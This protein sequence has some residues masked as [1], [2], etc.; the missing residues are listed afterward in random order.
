M[1]TMAGAVR[2][3]LPGLLLRQPTS[4]AGGGRRRARPVRHSKRFVASAAAADHAEETRTLAGY[5]ATEGKN[6]FMLALGELPCCV[7]GVFRTSAR[8]EC[9]EFYV[10]GTVHTP[11]S[12]SAEEVRRVIERLA[13]DAVSPKF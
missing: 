7:G 1:R 3:T 13:P 5:A 4:Q 11:G 8:G 12:G 9:F 6:D 2:G 10:V